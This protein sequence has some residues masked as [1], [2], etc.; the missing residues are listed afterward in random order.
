MP[1]ERNEFEILTVKKTGQS[2]DE[3]EKVMEK[4]RKQYDLNKNKSTDCLLKFQQKKI[5]EE[6]QNNELYYKY[7]CNKLHQ[8]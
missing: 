5:D 8:F 4:W 6:E 7:L 1:I 3:R 2:D